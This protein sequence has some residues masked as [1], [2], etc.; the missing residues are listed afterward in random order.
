MVKNLQLFRVIRSCVS[1]SILGWCVSSSHDPTDYQT[2]WTDSTRDSC[3]CCDGRKWA[4]AAPSRPMTSSALRQRARRRRLRDGTNYQPGHMHAAP[5]AVSWPFSNSNWSCGFSQLW[6][7]ELTL[8]ECSCIHISTN[9]KKRWSN[10]NTINT[11]NFLLIKDNSSCKKQV[12][13][14]P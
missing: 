10:G 8:L 14:S 3:V 12:E 6:R 9:R 5:R 2:D 1:A 13:I 11:V 7:M 4:A